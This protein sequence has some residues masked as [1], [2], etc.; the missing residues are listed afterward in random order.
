MVD[1]WWRERAKMVWE[2]I[3]ES[4][5]NCQG[6]KDFEA[7]GNFSAFLLHFVAKNLALG[8]NF[9][10]SLPRSNKENLFPN[11]FHAVLELK[12][13]RHRQRVMY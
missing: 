8:S 10:R 5:R 3:G 4:K 6:S 13:H 1:E 12:M 2:R 11:A 7:P 9:V